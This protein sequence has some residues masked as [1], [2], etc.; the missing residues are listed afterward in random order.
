M[1]QLKHIVLSVF[2]KYFLL[3]LGKLFRQKIVFKRAQKLRTFI[4]IEIENCETQDI[5]LK[6]YYTKK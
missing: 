4:S 3:I 2:Y 6:R 1:K 5:T